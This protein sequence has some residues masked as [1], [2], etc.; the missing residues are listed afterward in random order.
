MEKQKSKDILIVEDSA[1]QAELLRRLLI[2]EGYG[3][4][5]ARNGSEGLKKVKETR[6]DII[7]SDIV[8]PV[9]N[10]YEM[11]KEIK[12]NHEYGDVPVILLTELRDPGEIIKGIESGA[13]NYVTKPYSSDYLLRRIADLLSRRNGDV[14]SSEMGGLA[15]IINDERYEIKSNPQQILNLLLSTYENSIQQNRE[16]LKAQ[17]ELKR[18]NEQLEERVK[19]S[20]EDLLKNQ[21]YLQ[22]LMDNTTA[23]IYIK[24]LNGRYKMVN[25]QFEM[26]FDVAGLE[27][28][29]KTDYDIFPGEA[30]SSYIINDRMVL[31]KTAP[32]EMEEV[33]SQKDGLHTYISFK[34][35]LF[36]SNGKLSGVCG[37]STDIT[38]R[39]RAELELMRHRNH[40]EELVE[41]RTG[42][43]K[44]ANLQLH[45]E[46]EERKRIEEN[47]VRLIMDQER[48]N[49]ELNNLLYILSHD[50]KTPIR[51]IGSLADWIKEDH[52]V[53][54]GEDGM[55][56]MD[57]LI[58]RVRR[59]YDLLD[60]IYRYSKVG[61][62]VEKDLAIDISSLI[63]DITDTLPANEGIT[64]EILQ[65]MP[66]IVFEKSYI[67]QIF[68]NLISNAIKYNDKG[69]K[70]IKIGYVEEENFHKFYVSD[71]GV[72]IDE[73]HFERIFKIFQK[74]DLNDE[75]TSSGMG[76]PLIKKIIEMYGGRIWVES[77]IGEGSVFYFTLPK[78]VKC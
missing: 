18:L 30:A 63:R 66:E 44:K 59:M 60:S 69:S 58:S 70:V 33:F 78:G 24:D 56:N 27:I 10:G 40:L 20:T 11:C 38:E 3:V 16:L 17:I 2:Q 42:E 77:I 29:D 43:L 41:E 75:N 45:R 61:R 35:P 53:S 23:V 14:K 4:S 49:E 65:D 19:E 13:D 71:N 37:I 34:F 48:T 57:L 15:V 26:L 21:R 8:M 51:S 6:P 68:H 72:G 73:K 25:R 22:A 74:L 47:H 46:I 1:I 52:G 67:D 62:V 39:K 7:V 64:V 31:E 9:M 5:V 32:L 50:L 36:D 12:E 76:L 55:E 28:T 54:L